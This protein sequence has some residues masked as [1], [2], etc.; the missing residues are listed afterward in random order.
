MLKGMSK[1]WPIDPN[2]RKHVTLDKFCS[3]AFD[4]DL[5]YSDPLQLD[6]FLL[7]FL[8]CLPK[9]VCMGADY[10]G[11]SPKYSLIRA[12]IVAALALPRVERDCW[13]LVGQSQLRTGFSLWMFAAEESHSC[14]QL[15][16]VYVF[17]RCEH[18]WTS[19]MALSHNNKVPPKLRYCYT[20]IYYI[21]IYIYVY[22][23]VFSWA[24]AVFCVVPIERQNHGRWGVAQEWVTIR[25]KPVWQS[26]TRTIY[27]FQPHPYLPVVSRVWSVCWSVNIQWQCELRIFR[28]MFSWN[29]EDIYIYIFGTTSHF[30]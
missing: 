30:L 17:E 27:G 4:K 15:C 29:F 11:G 26:T 8:P 6:V 10:P 16:L 12:P 9:Y 21:Y 28:Q 5:I 14:N 24:E 23:I 2:F 18:V 20:I 3:F 13:T 25:P 22:T 7:Y 19:C 1:Y